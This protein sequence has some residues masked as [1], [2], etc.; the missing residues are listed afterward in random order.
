MTEMRFRFTEKVF[1]L[2]S[3]YLILVINIARYQD[4]YID[5]SRDLI[6][7]DFHYSLI[8]R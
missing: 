7:D 2:N 4:S 5:A 8:M 1:K 3:K 6:F